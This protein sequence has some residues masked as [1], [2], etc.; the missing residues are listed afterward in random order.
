ML[1]EFK[2]KLRTLLAAALVC[3]AAPAC[4]DLIYD[5]L[6]ECPVYKVKFRYD[7][8]MKYADAFAHEVK[9]VTLYVL[10]SKGSIVWSRS[11]SG[12]A[13]AAEDY[14]MVVKV[15]A[16]KYDLLAWCDADELGTFTFSEGTEKTA[17]KCSLDRKHAHDGSAYVD[18]DL[19]R[20]YYG[21]ESADFTSR[22]GETVA[23]VSLKKN[24]NHFQ[25]VLQHLSGSP[26]D[27]DIFDFSITDDNAL[28]DWD[29]SLMAGGDVTYRPWAVY[30]GEVAMNR[31][32]D[33]LNVAIAEFTTGR[34][35][36]GHNPRLN[37]RLKDSD[38]IVISIPLIDY[39]L[40]VKGK[41]NENLDNQEYLDRQDE[42]DMI[43]FLD[44]GERW[45][46]QYIYINSWKVVLQNAEL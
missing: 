7:W 5:D 34:I 31:A 36:L 44:D 25:V 2:V 24:T 12:E 46:N 14:S 39:A 40:L 45:V 41:Y 37:I 13:L 16:G 27:P 17:L 6:S 10:D 3:I 23:T 33:A 35:V 30:S 26:V 9:A 21:F 43:F 38:R 22:K 32:S 19:D 1:S 11:E 8:N 4:S 20:L 15:P 42:Y 28:M 18:S 29:N